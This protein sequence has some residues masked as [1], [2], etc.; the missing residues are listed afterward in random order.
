MSKLT[1][2][3]DDLQVDSFDTTRPE[4]DRGTVVGAQETWPSQYTGYAC[5][6]VCYQTCAV[7]CYEPSCEETC[8]GGTC[9]HQSCVATCAETGPEPCGC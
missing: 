8:G 4:K 1:L 9:F 2:Q 5:L 7:T 3:L 6:S